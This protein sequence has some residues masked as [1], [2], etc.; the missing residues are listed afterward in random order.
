MSCVDRLY[1]WF[2][3]E[4]K[5]DSGIYNVLVFGLVYGLVGGLVYGLVFGLVYGLIKVLFTPIFPILIIVL[6]IIIGMELIFWFISKQKPKSKDNLYLFVLKQKIKFA[7]IST[8]IIYQIQGILYVLIKIINYF[9][10]NYQTI[11]TLIKELIIW[12]GIGASIIVILGLFIYL[13]SL[14]FKQKK[15]RLD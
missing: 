2:L 7:T 4:Q 14:K 8:Y 9:N 5:K 15:I 10:L 12:F 13:N 3:Q 1:G 6:G 11:L